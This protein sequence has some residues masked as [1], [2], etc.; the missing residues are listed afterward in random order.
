MPYGQAKEILEYSR[1]FHR[2]VSNFYQK[3]ADKA[4]SARVKLLL[5]YMIHHEKH[6]EKSLKDFQ[7]GV[8]SQALNVW[9]QYSQEQ[10]AFAPLKTIKYDEK[11][12]VDD[13]IKIA[14][15][16]DKCL[17][18]SYKGVAETTRIPEIREIFQNLLQME[19][20]EKHVKARIALGINDM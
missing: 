5:D 15:D 8:S 18:E 13:V 19:N 11:M 16:I 1:E 7:Q 6:L 17:I 4:Q 9:Y 10:R 20:Q 3:M 14:A 2:Q 12:T